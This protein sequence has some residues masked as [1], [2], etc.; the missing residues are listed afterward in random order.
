MSAKYCLQIEQVF[1]S[2]SFMQTSTHFAWTTFG[3]RTSV[4]SVVYG[5][6]LKEE[7]GCSPRSPKKRLKI[8][9][10]LF[11]SGGYAT[12]FLVLADWNRTV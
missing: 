8:V 1:K 7:H 11:G 10:L 2:W 9:R 4:P 3:R 5:Q 12:N 6:E